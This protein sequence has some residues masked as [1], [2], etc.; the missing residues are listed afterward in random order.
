MRRLNDRQVSRS[1]HP[2]QGKIRLRHFIYQRSCQKSSAWH[3]RHHREDPSEAGAGCFDGDAG[4]VGAGGWGRE[5][6]DLD[7]GGATVNVTFAPDGQSLLA[8][9]P[10]APGI[11]LRSWVAEE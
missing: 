4:V 6:A 5:V 11:F 8:R 10:W 3:L 2:L 9:R 7:A 1:R